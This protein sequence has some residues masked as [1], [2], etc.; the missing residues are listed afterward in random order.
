[1]SIQIN[2]SKLYNDNYYW[3]KYERATTL[4]DRWL[5]AC[6]MN[7]RFYVAGR[8]EHIDDFYIK[9]INYNSISR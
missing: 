1:M 2:K 4:E 9:E 6:Y 5:I 8:K 7:G 3:L